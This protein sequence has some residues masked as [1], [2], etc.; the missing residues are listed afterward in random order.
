M[1]AM[2][3]AESL[4]TDAGITVAESFG[5]EELVKVSSGDKSFG[6][7]I[8]ECNTRWSTVVNGVRYYGNARFLGASSFGTADASED[9]SEKREETTK[10]RNRRLLMQDRS[11]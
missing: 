5:A 2:T 8:L 11:F 1:T 4:D 6:S 3:E 10:E 9:T 7:S